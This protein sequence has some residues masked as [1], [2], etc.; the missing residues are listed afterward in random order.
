MN[1]KIINIK[2][3]EEYKDKA[4]SFFASKWNIEES[5]Y[6]KSIEESFTSTTY[7]MWYL[8]IENG[9]IIG[10]IGVIENDFHERKDLSPNVCALYVKENRRNLGIAGALLNYVINDMKQKGI[11]KLYLITDHTSF[12]EKYNRKYFL[13]VKCD[14]GE[15]SRIYVHKE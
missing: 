15:I 4:A 8:A 2:D 12:Y 11:T 10:G 3:H 5:E 9:A 1:Y 6:L 13:D 7:P 14:G